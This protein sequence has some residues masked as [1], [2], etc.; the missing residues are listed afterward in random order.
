M[1]VDQDGFMATP[2]PPRRTSL[3]EKEPKAIRSVRCFGN[4]VDVS[5]LWS[6]LPVFAVDK[7][8]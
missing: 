1:I 7:Q 4:P 2:P 6:R 5:S 8:M 3:S